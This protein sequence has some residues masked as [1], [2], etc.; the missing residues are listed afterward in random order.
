MTVDLAYPYLVLHH[1]KFQVCAIPPGSVGLF[2]VPDQL[3][4]VFGY[5]FIIIPLARFFSASVD[6]NFTFYQ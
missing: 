6:I 1:S 2:T 5:M 3:G 4:Y